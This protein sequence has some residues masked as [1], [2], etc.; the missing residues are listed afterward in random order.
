[1]YKLLVEKYS[2]PFRGDEKNTKYNGLIMHQSF[3][4]LSATNN[5]N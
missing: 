4:I 1:M 5:G 3:K 2:P